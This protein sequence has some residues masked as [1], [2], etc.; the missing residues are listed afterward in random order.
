MFAGH[1]AVECQDEDGEILRLMSD[2]EGNRARME[3]FMARVAQG[4]A[5][6]SWSASRT[7]RRF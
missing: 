4:R 2:P 5:R 6:R 3:A 7:T 1:T